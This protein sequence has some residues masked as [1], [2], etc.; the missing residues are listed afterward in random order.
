MSLFHSRWVHGVGQ[1]Q[2]QLGLYR[3]SGRGV[4]GLPFGG[5]VGQ[6]RSVRRAGAG[7]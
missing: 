1:M 4:S 6:V 3:G 5:L 2:D 7:W